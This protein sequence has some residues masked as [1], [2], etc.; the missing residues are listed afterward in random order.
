MPD[1]AAVVDLLTLFLLPLLFLN[2]RELQHGAGHVPA[3]VL[4]ELVYALGNALLEGLSR[5]LG[6]R[7]QEILAGVARVVV[8]LNDG[9]GGVSGEQLL[10]RQRLSPR[11]HQLPQQIWAIPA[12]QSV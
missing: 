9:F 7:Q 5:G 12:M 4:E 11:P 1:V 2:L 8:F 3:A 10:R 6:I